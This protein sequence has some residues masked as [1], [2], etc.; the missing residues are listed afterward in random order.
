MESEKLVH[1]YE[2][3]ILPDADK[4]VAAARNAYIAGQIPLL[5]YLEA[6]RSKVSLRDRYYQTMAEY[7][8]RRATLERAGGGAFMPKP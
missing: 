8:Q 6:Q 1:L 4:N 2:D 5:S 3:T 7:H